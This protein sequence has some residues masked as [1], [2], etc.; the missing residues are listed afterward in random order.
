MAE[1]GS[2]LNRIANWRYRPA[3]VIRSMIG[4]VRLGIVHIEIYL[5][6][7]INVRWQHGKR[8]G[9]DR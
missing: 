6:G 7:N 2:S 1:G 4:N 3:A 8:V 9:E 5:D